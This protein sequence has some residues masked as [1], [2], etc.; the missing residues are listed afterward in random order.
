MLNVKIIRPGR[1]VVLCFGAIGGSNNHGRTNCSVL[2]KI[3][4]KE[5]FIRV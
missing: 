4:F 2:D 5:H 1:Q 3:F